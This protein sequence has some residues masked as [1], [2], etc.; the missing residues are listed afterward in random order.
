MDGRVF[1]VDW[2]S[3]ANN[4]PF[5]DLGELTV[6][7]CRTAD[8]RRLLLREYLT[9]EPDDVSSARMLVSRLVALGFYS[10]GFAMIAAM[11]GAFD[12]S[13]RPLTMDA[14]ALSMTTAPASPSVIAASLFAEMERG[15]VEP[16][17]A[18]AKRLLGG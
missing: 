17:Y 5:F 9:R 18:D 14:L 6:F 10:G 13:A 12:A 3:A 7:G 4:D 1:F 8:A 15:M 16:S 11:G 2:D